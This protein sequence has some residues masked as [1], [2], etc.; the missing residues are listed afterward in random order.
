MVHFFFSFNIFFSIYIVIFLSCLFIRCTSFVT[1]LRTA[2]FSFVVCYI[3]TYITDSK[4]STYS[5]ILD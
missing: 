2:S 5:I 1:V 4:F 3:F